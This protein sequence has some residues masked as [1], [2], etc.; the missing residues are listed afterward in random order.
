MDNE[1][2]RDTTYY[3]SINEI[4]DNFENVRVASSKNKRYY[5]EDYFGVATHHYYKDNLSINLKLYSV[6]DGHA[7]A[8]TAHFAISE[9]PG[10][11]I[12]CL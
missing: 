8:H 3:N 2:Q 12:R 4:N 9:L 11:N 1:S 6:L 5:M 10:Y 7:G